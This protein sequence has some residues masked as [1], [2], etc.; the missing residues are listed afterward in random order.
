[1]LCGV[2]KTSTHACSLTC[3]RQDVPKGTV[4]A[5]GT[6]LSE[7]ERGLRGTDVTEA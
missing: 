6:T 3:A 2:T 1:M 7:G 5:V 4:I